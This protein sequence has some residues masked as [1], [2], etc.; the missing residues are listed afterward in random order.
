MKLCNRTL[1][2][3]LLWVFPLAANA[4][5]DYTTNIDN[6]ITITGYTGAGGDVIIPDT[7]NNL[8][9]TSIGHGAFQQLTSLTNVTIGNSVTNIADLSFL[10]TGL[11]SVKIPNSVL[12]IGFRAFSDCYSLTSVTIGTNVIAL[13]TSCFSACTSLGSIT[14]PNSVTY[15][16]NRSFCYCSSLT[17]VIIGN[18][19]TNIHYGLFDSCP[20]LTSAFFQGN[21]PVLDEGNIFGS[22]PVTVYCYQGATGFGSIFSGAPVVVLSPP[23]T[24]PSITNQPQDMLVN[25]HAPALFSVSV[26]GT[27]PLYY[28]WS[29]NNSNLLNAISSTLSIT[30]VKQSDL[31]A[32]VVV[33]TNGYGTATS[34]VANLYMYPI[35]QNPFKGVVIYWGQTNTLSVGAWGSALSYQWFKDGVAIANA[36]DSTLTLSSIQFTDAGLYS[37]VVSN[38]FGIVTNAP[39]QVVVNA[40]DISLGLCPEVKINGTV[41]YSYIIQSTVDLSNTNLWLTL[42][43]LTL[44][45]PFQIWADTSTDTTQPSNPRKYYRVLPGQ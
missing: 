19:V 8:L 14:I 26:T 22:D 20:S 42:T 43:N 11:K 23:S 36:T 29:L 32:Y 10:G 17:N 45:Q 31:G 6:T 9:V 38:S 24:P 40:A 28:R 30:N 16:G 33:V 5:F 2:L 39:Y 21:A 1:L 15:I 37:V 25:A 34:H 7:I 12:Y 27:L 13:E 4:Q 3:V 44:T 41:G 35:L 18:G